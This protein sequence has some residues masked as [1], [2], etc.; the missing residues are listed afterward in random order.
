MYAFYLKHFSILYIFNE[1]SGRAQWY[2]ARLRH[3]YRGVL[4]PVRAGNFSSQPR[5]QT[6]SGAHTS[7]SPTVTRGSFHG[8]KGEADHPLLCSAEVKNAW[9][10][11]STPPGTPLLYLFNSVKETL[12]LSLRSVINFERTNEHHNPVDKQNLS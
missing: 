12:P 2:S 6:G 1:G 5:V 9:S 11:S 8:S 3:G 4:V 7:S 10:Y